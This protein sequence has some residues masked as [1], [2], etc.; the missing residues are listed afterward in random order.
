MW[1]PTHVQVLVKRAKG[2]NVKGKGGTND[3]FVTIGLGKE[4]FQTSVKEKVTDPVDWSE[5]CELSIPSQGNSAELLLTVLHRNFMGVDEFLGQISVPLQDFDVYEKPKA[6]WYSLKCKPGKNKTDYRGELEVKCGFTVKATET[7]NGSTTDLAKKTKG[8]LTS[9]NKVT[10]SL[11]GSLLSLGGKE[12]K[13]IKKLA[14]SVG[15]KVEKASEK[16]RKSVSSMK[17]NKGGQ[18]ESLPEQ[19]Q[20]S[21]LDRRP[22]RGPNEDPGVNSDDEDDMFQFDTLSNKSSMSS[23]NTVN[24]LGIVS[25]T[26]TPVNGSLENLTPIGGLGGLAARNS[27]KINDRQ[28]SNRLSSQEISSL[29]P[30][31]VQP[32]LDDWEAKLLGKKT[33]QQQVV[34][35]EDNVSVYSLTDRERTTSVTSQVTIQDNWMPEPSPHLTRDVTTD[36]GSMSSLPT[37]REA[38]DKPNTGTKK[39]IIPV[40]SDSE[41]SPS[42]DSSPSE[43]QETPISSGLNSQRFR[44]SFNSQ[45]DELQDN[46]KPGMLGRLKNSYSFKDIPT[47]KKSNLMTTSV[48][49]TSL[50][51]SRTPSDASIGPP[52]GTRIVVGRETSPVPPALSK[53]LPQEIMERYKDQSRE[54][55][56]EMVI[57]LQASVEH[58]G[59]KA[60]DLEDYIDSLLMRVME[61]APILLQKDQIQNKSHLK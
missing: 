50:R 44:R 8:S 33:S 59:R 24:K 20:W 60:G 11:G 48:D 51:H 37:Y 13:N 35:E 15:Q 43:F 27:F 30:A 28:Q 47:D 54:D 19:S 2:L 7:T 53:T 18:L 26:S 6:K 36:K 5:Q 21:T 17:L 45:S 22:Q 3:A 57:S 4:K 25:A 56:I 1:S 41:S 9:L 55:L 12:K 23:L 32:V 29:P 39:M 14:K 34:K 40:Q 49:S 52:N 58:Q 31:N 10:G 16:A 38:M 42:P 46:R 61:T